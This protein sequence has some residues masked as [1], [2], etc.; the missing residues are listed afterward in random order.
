RCRYQAKLRRASAKL[1]PYGHQGA[2]RPP[3][4]PLW[5]RSRLLRVRRLLPV[6]RYAPDFLRYRKRCSP[7]P[8]SLRREAETVSPRAGSRVGGG[9]HCQSRRRVR[10]G[11]HAS[12]VPAHARS[13]PSV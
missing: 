4:D 10:P 7:V 5:C 6:S 11:R 13:V 1:R 8:S 12:S 9:S 2:E 3:L